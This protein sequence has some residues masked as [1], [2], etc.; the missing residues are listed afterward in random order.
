[1]QDTDYHQQLNQLRDSFRKHRQSA[2]DILNS[3]QNDDELLPAS[4]SFIDNGKDAF[5]AAVISEVNGAAL[6]FKLA[7]TYT[8]YLA[9]RFVL[10]QN[11]RPGS[12]LTEQAWMV[13]NITK[14]IAISLQQTIQVVFICINT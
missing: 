3:L 10:S 6:S 14:Q 8:L 1:M 11:F 5:F 2:P 4:L 7:P 12:N 9:A 13:S